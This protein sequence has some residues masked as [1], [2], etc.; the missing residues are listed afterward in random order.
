MAIDLKRLR[1]NRKVAQAEKDQIRPMLD[2]LYRYVAPYR[3]GVQQTG[4]GEK[5]TN[6]VHDHTAIVSNY[7]SANRLA[8]DISPAGP[9]SFDLKIGPIAK[10]MMDQG[11][12]KD[13]SVRIEAISTVTS[14][15]F[16][17]GEW[18][19]SLATM[20]VD[21]LGSTGAMLIEADNDNRRARFV[22]A[23]I[24]ELMLTADGYGKVNGIYWTR[25]WML[26]AG[27]R[28]HIRQVAAGTQGQAQ[29]QPGNRVRVEPGCGVGCEGQALGAGGLD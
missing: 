1:A 27:R 22:A 24:D 23:S 19:L 6:M 13:F 20:C 7:R 8:N 11:Q 9:Q 15:Q 3:K 21:V 14:A 10:L 28:I 18:D 17:T 26:R 16:L 2:D 4:K 25:R 29:E 5:R 12:Q